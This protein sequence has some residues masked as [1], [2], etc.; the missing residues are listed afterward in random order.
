MQKSVVDL[1]VQKFG[2]Q[3]FGDAIRQMLR[4]SHQESPYRAAD[5]SLQAYPGLVHQSVETNAEAPVDTV[6]SR[7]SDSTAW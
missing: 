2:V 5:A 1:I 4:L 6:R 3:K 7:T